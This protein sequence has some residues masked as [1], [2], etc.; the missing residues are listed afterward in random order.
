MGLIAKDKDIVVPGELLA[1]GMDFLPSSGTYRQDSNI[2]AERLGILV[3]EGKV[4]K[5]IPLS[6]RYLPKRNDVIVGRVH[7]ILMSGWRIEFNSPY[8]AV[9]NLKDATYDFIA[10]QANLTKYFNLDDYL[11]CKIINVTSQ[12]LVDVTCKGP[13]LQKLRGGRIVTV[14]THKVPRIIGKHGSMVT[15]LKNATNC[16]ITVGQNG[17]IWIKGDPK[18]ELIAVNTIIKIEA[19]SHISGLTERIK[20]YLEEQTG[21]P[22]KMPDMEAEGGPNELH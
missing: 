9:L 5:T 16:Q 14:N 4:L 1:Q 8:T 21:R 22:V 6:G 18:S 12:N 7:D 20:R 3:V 19:E 15:M 10:R 2:M 11:V 17:L 13:G